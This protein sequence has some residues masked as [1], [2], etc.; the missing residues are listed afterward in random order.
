MPEAAGYAPHIREPD[1]HEPRLLKGL[2]T[3]INLHVFSE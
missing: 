2:D 3:D 1:W